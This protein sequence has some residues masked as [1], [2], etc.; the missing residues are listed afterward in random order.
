MSDLIIALIGLG[1]VLLGA[2]YLLSRLRRSV[3]REPRRHLP[4][5]ARRRG[6]RLRGA[7][8]QCD[9][10]GKT[11]ILR[12]QQSL[13]LPAGWFV[14]VGPDPGERE[15]FTERHEF[16]SIACVAEFAHRVVETR[17]REVAGS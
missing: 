13:D 2:E 1:Y 16:C 3:R 5:R 9:D 7:G 11:V 15:V 10:C 6:A 8:F 17:A 12:Q 14:L 4:R